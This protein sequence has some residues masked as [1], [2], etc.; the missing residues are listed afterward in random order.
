M[1]SRVLCMLHLY[2]LIINAQITKQARFYAFSLL[3][4]T[5]SWFSRPS[6]MKLKISSGI[7]SP[8]SNKTCFSSSCQLRV[9]YCTPM[10]SQWLL[11]CIPAVFTIFDTL[12]EIMNSKSYAPYSSHINSPSFIL[13]TPT[14]FS[15]SASSCCY[16]YCYGI[17]CFC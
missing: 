11:S 16:I 2:F 15:S 5:L 10:L 1:N 17:I 7:F 3:I 14:R 4:K 8:S 12:F 6:F 13:M 9:K